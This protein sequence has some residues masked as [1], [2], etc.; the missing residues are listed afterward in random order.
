MDTLDYIGALI[1]RWKR[2]VFSN[3]AAEPPHFRNVSNMVNGRQHGQRGTTHNIPRGWRL[4]SSSDI[5]RFPQQ[6]QRQCLLPM[7]YGEYLI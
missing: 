4:A 6:A 3:N 5:G 7:S 1:L 2:K